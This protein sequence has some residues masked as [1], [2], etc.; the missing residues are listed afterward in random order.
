MAAQKPPLAGPPIEQSTLNLLDQYSFAW[1][2][3]ADH[4]LPDAGRRKQ[5]REEAHN[6]PPRE[7][8]RIRAAL[9]AGRFVPP[10]IV[11][12]DG[13]YVDGNTRGGAYEKSGVRRAH[14]IVLD[15]DFETASSD[16]QRRLKGLGAALNLAHGNRLTPAETRDAV[17]TLAEDPNLDTTRIA[18]LLGEPRNT[19]ARI[20]RRE[21]GRK[22]LTEQG[23]ETNGTVTDGL[24]SVFATRFN[25][26]NA[27]PAKRITELA[28]NADLKADEV[29]D[30]ARRV[31]ATDS[32]VAAT[33]VLDTAAAELSNRIERV[34][35][36]GRGRPTHAGKVRRG[37][38]IVASLLDG[39]GL[40][41]GVDTDPA[42]AVA[43]LAELELVVERLGKLRDLQAA[44]N[45]QM[46]LDD[47]NG[48]GSADA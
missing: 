10:T 12:R 20:M 47:A 23:F 27:E 7:V 28:M 40:E 35:Y 17:I 24:L 22:W 13:Y 25:D 5:I 38:G 33:E 26:W 1:R 30:L 36:Q 15:V 42:T 29:K 11:T 37:M 34:K 3:E 16:V 48:N 46:T 31:E 21:R 4:P 39:D 6:A 9:A 14:A 43:Y 19:V 18:E 41:R 2:Y 44:H 32:D 8:D 45:A